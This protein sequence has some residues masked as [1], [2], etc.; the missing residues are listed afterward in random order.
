MCSAWRLASG[1]LVHVTGRLVSKNVHGEKMLVHSFYIS[2]F[3]RKEIICKEEQMDTKGQPVFLINILSSDDL[4]G[5][6]IFKCCIIYA[7]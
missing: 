7:L 3:K 1:R 5:E 6:V 4:C 2:P